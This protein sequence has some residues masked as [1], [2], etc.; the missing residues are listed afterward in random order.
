LMGGSWARG[1]AAMVPERMVREPAG[2]P[3]RRGGSGRPERT[4]GGGGPLLH[5]TLVL[6]ALLTGQC[7]ARPAPQGADLLVDLR[8]RSLGDGFN[9]GGHA[10]K[11]RPPEVKAL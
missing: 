1:R 10:V 9:S 8:S 11:H 2:G 6:L 4:V 5:E 3:R 7:P